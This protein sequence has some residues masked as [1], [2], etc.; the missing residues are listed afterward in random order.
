MAKKPKK[1][2]A[3]DLL[4]QEVRELTEF[5]RHDPDWEGRRHFFR[6]RG[7]APEEFV[8]GGF[9]EDEIGN[10]YGVI[11]TREHKVFEYSRSIDL[12][13]RRGKLKSWTEVSDVDAATKENWAALSVAAQL[14]DVLC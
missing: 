11:V 2:I 4:E 3:R 5:I 6:L 10:E 13:K 14:V 12:P 8:M 7:L 9:C 1:T